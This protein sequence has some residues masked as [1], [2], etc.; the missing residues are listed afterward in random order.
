MMKA[1][2]KWM[3]GRY[4]QNG[5]DSFGWFLLITGMILSGMPFVWVVSPF[6]GGWQLY[7]LMS[8]NVTV[9]FRE[10][11]DFRQLAGKATGWL[12]PVLRP[13]KAIAGKAVIGFAGLGFKGYVKSRKTL[14]D[15]KRLL[16]QGRKRFAERKTNLFVRCPQCRNMLR[17]PR[18]KGRLEATC[19][20]CRTKFEQ[21]T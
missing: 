21:R 19:P 3:Q 4:G 14:T 9:R 12:S 11:Q 20:V 7:R 1:Y 18:G 10:N 5:I 15:G 17:L 16:S 6:L 8:R 13:L 2:L